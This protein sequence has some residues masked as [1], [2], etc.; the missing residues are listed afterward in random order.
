[1]LRDH[2]DAA[3][4]APAQRAVAPSGGPGRPGRQ[5]ARRLLTG[6][7]AAAIVALMGLAIAF[8]PWAQ[9]GTVIKAADPGLLVAA[10]AASLGVYPLWIWQWRQIAAPLRPVRW[11]VM[12]QVVALSIGARVTVSGLGGVASGGAALHA[13]AGLSAAESA[14][15][16]TV[17]QML[18]G[19]AKLGVLVLALAIAPVPPA[20][21]HVGFG[22]GAALVAAGLLLV[23]LVRIGRAPNRVRAGRLGA[24]I[25]GFARDFARLGTPRVILPAAG[26]ALAK[27]ALEIA[28]AYA[29][30]RSLGIDGSPAPAILAVLSV[31][32]VSLVPIAPVQ[33]GPQAL[34]V[35]ATYAALGTPTAEAVSVAVLHQ[36]LMLVSTLIIGAVAL[37]FA[38]RPA[39]AKPAP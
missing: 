15:V 26:L 14:G 24:A 3:R 34:A 10:L 18:A 31:S 6:A 4:Q 7:V 12:A 5:A 29:I 28:A 11:P 17:D 33:L 16:M 25:A 21:R 35:F 19:G 27:K 20:V 2:R 38:I 13:H 36:G 8:T 39:R 23:V 1:M 32:L 9:V 37:A 30:Q 22:L